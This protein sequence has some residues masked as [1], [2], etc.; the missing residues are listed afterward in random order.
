MPAAALAE[1]VELVEGGTPSGKLAKDVFG[2][3]WTERRAAGDIVAAEGLAQVSDSGALEAACKAVDAN[4]DE[5][6]R[7]RAGNAKLLGFFVGAVMK[8]TGGKANP[9]AVNDILRRLLGS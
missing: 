3:M 6:S 5:V 8:E 9:K 2:R 4:P 1:L 7:F